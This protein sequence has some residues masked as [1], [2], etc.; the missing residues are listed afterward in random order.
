MSRLVFMSIVQKGGDALK[1][2]R[3]LLLFG[4]A[5]CLVSVAVMFVALNIEEKGV[6]DFVPPRF[7]GSAQIGIP[8]VPDGL[9]WT[10]LNAQV[11]SVGICGKFTVIDDRADVW[12]YNSSENTVWMKL[13]V[14]DETGNILGET[15]LI[16][17]N[18]YIQSVILSAIPAVGTPIILKFMTYEPDTYY[19]AGAVELNTVV[20]N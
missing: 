18:E 8:I 7:D 9:G 16:K 4:I 15:G 2:I 12:F 11:F 17:P 3:R 14:L 6:V 1:R 13:R 20:S 19:S 5:V 10:E